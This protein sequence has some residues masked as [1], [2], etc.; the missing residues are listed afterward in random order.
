MN[1]SDITGR[2]RNMWIIDFGEMEIQEAA[3][4]EAPFEY[5]KKNILGFAHFQ[6]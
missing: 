2:N 3:Q 6:E 1:G 4:Y 5:V